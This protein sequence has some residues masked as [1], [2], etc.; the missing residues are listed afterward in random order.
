MRHLVKS[1][2]ACA[3][4]ALRG[5]LT[6]AGGGEVLRGGGARCMGGGACIDMP[7][8]TNVGS[9]YRSTTVQ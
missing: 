8:F 6:L 1:R 3:E 2:L 5:L 9:R 4:A 7:R